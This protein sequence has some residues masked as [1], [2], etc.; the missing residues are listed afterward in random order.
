M[1]SANNLFKER[2]RSSS[3]S[4]M[5]EDDVDPFAEPTAEEQAANSAAAATS[6]KK[7][8]AP[9]VGKST[10]VLAVKPADSD[11]DLDALEVKVR[12]IQKEGLLWG[13]S[14]REEMC[15]GLFAIQI[16][17][18]VTDDVSVDDIQEEI[19]G[20]EDLVASTEIQ[21]FQKI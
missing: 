1:W 9:Q 14:Q 20:W 13:K 6:G 11:V 10:L 17:A 18:V 2:P 8:K 4:Q 21:A 3:L 19:E 7:A 12:G 5:A 15:F 16:G